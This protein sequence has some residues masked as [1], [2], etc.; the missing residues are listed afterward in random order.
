MEFIDRMVGVTLREYND[1]IEA[2]CEAMLTSPEPVGV[3]VEEWPDGEWRVSLSPDE[4][5]ME[6][7]TR[8]RV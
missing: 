3:L 7:T 8:K 1:A 6:I 2:A 5:P 4:T